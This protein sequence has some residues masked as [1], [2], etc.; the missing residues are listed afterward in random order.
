[1]LNPQESRIHQDLSTASD[2]PQTGERLNSKIW[3]DR[4]AFKALEPGKN[5]VE[6]T[7]DLPPLDLDVI[8]RQAHNADKGDRSPVWQGKGE[9]PFTPGETT[10]ES[11]EIDGE[12]RTFLLH[13]PES[14]DPNKPT[15][16]IMAYHGI[17]STGAEMEERTGLSNRSE[18]DNFIVAYMEGDPEGRHSWNNGQLAFSGLDDVKFTRETLAKISEN[19]HIDKEHVYAVGFSQG[20][21][22]VHR[23]AN[24][25]ELKNT[26]KAIGVVGGW[27]TGREKIQSDPDNPDSDDLSVIS[28][29]SGADPTSPYDGKFHWGFANMKPESY[30][31][32]FY[33]RRNEVKEPAK[34]ST[35]YNDEGKLIRSQFLSEDPG[36]GKKVMRVRIED[37]GH[38]WP[39]TPET[40]HKEND[41]T[42]MILKFFRSLD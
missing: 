30:E 19:L 1:M 38:I 15:H 17:T 12:K 37:E 25:P 6:D 24:E 28:I 33:R 11:I 21:S 40:V 35:F 3:G 32:D 16:L 27:M 41:A 7:L 23:L 31:E 22:M 29:K 13:V 26:F 2:N 42:D 20:E 39:G 18:S 36:S 5:P 14:Y 8:D 10:K 34:E 4:D 9:L